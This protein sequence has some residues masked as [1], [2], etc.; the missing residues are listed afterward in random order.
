MEFF[1]I[2]L[3]ASLFTIY[4]IGLTVT[5]CIRRWGIHDL[6]EWRKP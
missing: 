5:L 2:L 4:L 1:M 3:I 6:T